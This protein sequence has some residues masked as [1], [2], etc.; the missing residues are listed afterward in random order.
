MRTY[1][2]LAACSVTF[3]LASASTTGC[4]SSDGGASAD[5]GTPDAAAIDAAGTDGGPADAATC[6]KLP[7]SGATQLVVPSSNADDEVG[8]EAK[9]VLDKKGRPVVAYLDHPA[10]SKQTLYIVRWDD[11][12]GAWLPPQKI[13]D[14]I[15]G[16]ISKASRAFGLAVDPTDGRIALAYDKVVHLVTPPRQN[17]TS[18][19]FV[20]VSSDDGATFTAQRVSHH[21][22]ETTDAEGDIND[23]NELAVAMGGGK[24]YVAY[25]QTYHACKGTSSCATAAVVLTGS[26]GTFTEALV[27]D[28][29][30]TEHGGHFVARDFPIGIAVDTAGKV[31]VVVHREPPTAYDTVV[32]FWRAGDADVQVV[33]RSGTVQNDEGAASLAFDG[34][35]PRVLTRL[36]QGTVGGSNSYDLTFSSSDGTSG[37][38]T[39]IALPRPDHIQN[40]E[41]LLVGSG[42]VVVV[43]GGPHVFRSSDSTTFVLDELGLAQHSDG[44]DGTLD[45]TGKLWAVVE[46]LTPANS[47]LGGVVFYREP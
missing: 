23:V 22:C 12:A 42:K 11:C 4:S 9:I 31:G 15:N 7:A 38:W 40:T 6:G 18:A 16:S 39:T 28:S 24:T 34:T 21:D 20:A 44:V 25:T 37:G 45:A 19:A 33:T 30:D 8:N 26:G 3:G 41:K 17:D 5:G 29:S 1:L 36:Q 10:S 13:D 2:I 14:G 46:G 27:P 43:A 35:A 47:S 32:G